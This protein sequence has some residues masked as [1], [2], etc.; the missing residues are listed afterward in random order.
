MKEADEVKL[1]IAEDTSE[2]IFFFFFQVSFFSSP[3]NTNGVK[4]FFFWEKKMRICLSCLLQTRLKWNI[5]FRSIKAFLNMVRVLFNLPSFIF[6]L[7]LSGFKLWATQRQSLEIFQ[8]YIYNVVQF[9]FLIS[10]IYLAHLNNNFCL[11]V[12]LIPIDTIN[13]YLP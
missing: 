12:G 9:F 5:S 2:W 8:C 1:E 13:V 10:F 7:L 4:M 3:N 11:L 6:F